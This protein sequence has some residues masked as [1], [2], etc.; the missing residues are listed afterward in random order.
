M[1]IKESAY[2][3]HIFVDS[4][5]LYQLKPIMHFARAK[6][7]ESI[8]SPGKHLYFGRLFALSFERYTV[9]ANDNQGG[10]R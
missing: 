4:A 10:R 7:H 9:I 1:V 3:V 5:F 8:F 2:N 6:L